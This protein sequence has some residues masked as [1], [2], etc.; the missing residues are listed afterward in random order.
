LIA[1][2]RSYSTPIEELHREFLEILPQI[3]SH[4]RIYFRHVRCPHRR[5]DAIQEMRSLGWKWFV[6]LA[7]KGRDARE[8]PATFC[9]LL[10]RV[11]RCG[12][13]L[14]G[15]EKGRDVMNVQTQQRHHFKVERLPASASCSRQDLYSD[16]NG[17]RDQDAL[18]A[19]LHDNSTTP[20]PDQASFRI[21]FPNWRSTCTERDRGIMN[22]LMVGE[23]T[24]DVAHKFGLSA[25]RVS[26]KRQE[27]YQAWRRFIGEDTSASA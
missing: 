2:L 17:Q 25:G 19:T 12:R 11:V 18:E 13:R 20:P 6:R 4:G 14:C 7:Q 26:Q 3:E 10:G 22:L 24:L 15:M 8:F 21:D 5:A 16:P 23:R 27:F 9:T 1:F